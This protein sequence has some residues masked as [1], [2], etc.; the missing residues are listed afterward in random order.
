MLTIPN[1]NQVILIVITI[2]REV[3]GHV[4]SVK[5]LVILNLTGYMFTSSGFDAFIHLRYIIL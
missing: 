4:E 2:A 3:L 5:I 1:K